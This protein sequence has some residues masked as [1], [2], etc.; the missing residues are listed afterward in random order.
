[1]TIV[2]SD[3]TRDEPRGDLVRAVLDELGAEVRLTVAI[4]NGTHAPGDVS[5]LD[6][7]P[8]VVPLVVNHDSTD[9]T[10]FVDV[11]VTRRG[12]RVRFPQ[13]LTR[14]DLVVA[15]GRIKPH[16]FAGFGAGAKAIFPGLGVREDIRQNHLLKADPTARI[17]RLTG[18][19]CREDMEEAVRLLG[20]ETFLLNVVID[21]FGGVRAVAGD[22][23]VAHRALADESRPLWTVRSPR[24]DVV[25]VSESLP[26]T[27]SLYQA[28]KLLAPAAT[29]LRDGGT[30]VLAAECPLGTGPLA[31]VNDGIYRLGIQPLF[32]RHIINMVSSLTPAVVAQTYCQYAASVESVLATA[33]GDMVVIPRA[34]DLIPEVSA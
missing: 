15:C 7:P 8:S 3:A 2:V 21:G 27:A 4:A 1:M 34:G 19:V 11:G 10:D 16:Y 26:V 5:A 22:V 31:V 23:V 12:T 18:N 17:G 24:A 13:W 14:Q 9:S 28:S 29:I 32:G 33:T 20:V 25:V 6:L 30:V